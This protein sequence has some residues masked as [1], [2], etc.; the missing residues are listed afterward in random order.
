MVARRVGRLQPVRRVA[1]TRVPCVGELHAHRAAWT[2]PGRSDLV[3]HRPGAVVAGNAGGRI[4]PHGVA[5]GQRGACRAEHD[6]DERDGNDDPHQAPLVNSTTPV[7]YRPGTDGVK[8][9]AGGRRENDSRR[10]QRRGVRGETPRCTEIGDA[11][12]EQGV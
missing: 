11:P 3:G 9:G 10:R 2:Q 8:R 4:D 5:L 6:D 12:A 7:D 1:L